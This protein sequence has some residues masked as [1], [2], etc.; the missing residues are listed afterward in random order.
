[1]RR[2]CFGGSFNP[3]HHAHLLCARAVAESAGFDR[4]V[5]IPSSQPPHKPG[6]T[7]LAPPADRLEMCRLATGLQ[8]DSFEVDDIEI[9]R[10]GSSFTIDTIRDLKR[11]GGSEVHWLIGADMLMYLPQW[12]EPI[13]LLQEVRFVVMARPGTPI[14]WTQLPQPFRELQRN[15]VPS[16]LIDISATTLR[17]RLKEGKSIAYMTPPPV[18]DYIRKKRLYRDINPS[19]KSV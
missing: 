10:G 15:I 18:V 19:L 16:P 1:M 13:A 6:Q 9:Q 14:D 11:R 12:H 17:R 3:I 4:V 5:L 2:L 7:D 8:P